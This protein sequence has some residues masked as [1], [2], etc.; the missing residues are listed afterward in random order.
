MFFVNNR[1]GLNPGKIKLKK[2]NSASPRKQHETIL[3]AEN[4]G[5]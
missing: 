4:N 5:S 2:L 3:S 1:Y